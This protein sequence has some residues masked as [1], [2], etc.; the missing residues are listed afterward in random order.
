M[1]YRFKRKEEVPK[2]I[3]RIV[4]EQTGRA[5]EA[6]GRASVDDIHEAVHDARKRFK[7]TRSVLRLMRGELG[8]DI[9]RRENDWFRYAGRRLAGARDAE[10]M[11]ETYDKL[12][13]RYPLV[14]DC[15]PLTRLREAL[16]RRRERIVEERQDLTDIARDLAARLEEVPDR[17]ENWPLKTDGFDAFA[18]GLERMYRRGRK[19]FH[20]ACRDPG[21]ERFHDWRKRVKDS[22]Y[23]A[24][25]LR[26][27]WPAVLEAQVDE[28][29]RLSDLLGDD[30]DLAV[31]RATLLEE[32]DYLGAGSPILACLAAQR[33]QELRDEVRELGHRLYAAKP[34]C[35]IR[36]LRGYWQAWKS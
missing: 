26:R 29:K 21:D 32:K 10:A 22:W 28:L 8:D 13:E 30:H 19:A 31:L 5:A 36:D 4:S 24:R 20:K 35:E 25:L 23:H 18:P 33:Q 12:A 9:Y 6:L 16:V 11:I 2:S 1:P 27:T 34:D 14:T 17:T 15:A 7:K 3:V